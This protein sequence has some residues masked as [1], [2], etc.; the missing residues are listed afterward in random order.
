MNENM[1]FPLSGA[2]GGGSEKIVQ[3]EPD[4]NYLDHNYIDVELSLYSIQAITLGEL[5][6]YKYLGMLTSNPQIRFENKDFYDSVKNTD[7]PFIIPTTLTVSLYAPESTT[8]VAATITIER[9][10]VY[11]YADKY[12]DGGRNIRVFKGKTSYEIALSTFD[13]EIEVQL[14]SDDSGSFNSLDW[15]GAGAE[16]GTLAIYHLIVKIDGLY[17]PIND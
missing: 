15:D 7:K 12:V 6:F 8:T 10:I 3:F 1:Y 4:S 13:I 17:L 16:K 2:A 5:S 11:Y 9:N 14:Q